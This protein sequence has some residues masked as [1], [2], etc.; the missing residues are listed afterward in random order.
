MEFGPYDLDG[1]E[2]PEFGFMALSYDKGTGNGCY[3]MRMDP[4]SETVFHVHEGVEDFYVLE[5]DLIDDD[6]TVFGPGDFVSYE[7]GSRH[8]SRSQGGCVLL[9]CEWGKGAPAEQG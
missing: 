9:V 7:P 4:D 8:N 1:P 6:G 3:L 5:G 2:Q